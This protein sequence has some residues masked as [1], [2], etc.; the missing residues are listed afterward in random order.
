MY[1]RFADAIRNGG[2]CDPDFN[3]AV[4]THRLIDA[5]AEASEEGR[6]VTL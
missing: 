3:T 2:E 4:E 1:I 5:I 6:A